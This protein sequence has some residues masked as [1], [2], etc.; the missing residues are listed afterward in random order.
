MKKVQTVVQNSGWNLLNDVLAS[1]IKSSKA[2]EDTLNTRFISWEMEIESLKQKVEEYRKRANSAQEKV[3]DVK[4]SVEQQKQKLMK[5][6]SKGINMFAEGAKAS[7]QKEIDCIAQSRSV[8][9]QAGKSSNDNQN[10]KTPEFH[11]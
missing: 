5:G 6:F 7:I 8:K 4:E 1:L 2:I 3:E 10:I 11:T 9:Y